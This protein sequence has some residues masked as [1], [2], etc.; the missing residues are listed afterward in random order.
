MYQTYTESRTRIGVTNLV[1]ALL[2]I[3]QIVFRGS[4]VGYYKLPSKPLSRWRITF[5]PGT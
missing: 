4:S 5:K 1:T 2:G 3:G